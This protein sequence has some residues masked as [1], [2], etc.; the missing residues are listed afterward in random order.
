M[1]DF[2]TKKYT[3]MH[4]TKNHIVILSLFFL[5][6]LTH[7]E[8]TAQVTSITIPNV[9]TP[10]DDGYN[11]EFQ[12]SVSGETIKTFGIKIYNSW[13]TLLFSS[14]NINVSWDGRTIAGEKAAQGSYFYMVTI[15]N[16]IY[17]GMLFLCY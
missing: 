4:I 9:F 2:D 13:G 16:N 6:L 17:K 8:T 1:S 14:K 5:F 11:D 15:N 3:I 7:Q 12:I 10:N